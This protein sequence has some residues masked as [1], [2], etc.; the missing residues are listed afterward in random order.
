MWGN[1]GET[2]EGRETNH[3]D[4][5]GNGLV[6]DSRGWDWVDHDNT[7][8]D[9]NGH[10]THVAGTIGAR[11][12]NAVGV[13]GVDWHVRIVP[14]RA[15][16][17]GGSGFVSDL[18][19]AYNYAKQ[20][21]IKIVNASLGGDNSSQAE[22]DA[23]A[24]APNTLF[25]VAA[26]NDAANNDI[27]GSFPCNYPL[28][29]VLCVAATDQND[30]LAS[31]SNYG[32]ATVD[33]A[34]PGV[35]IE[36]TYPGGEYAYMDGTSM[37]TPHVSGTA[38]LVWSKDPG[39]TAAVV[40]QTLFTSADPKP[41][42]L[43]KTVTGGRLNASRA[44]GVEPPTVTAPPLPPVG[45]DNSPPP[46]SEPPPPSPSSDRSSPPARGK[47]SDRTPPRVSLA[48]AR[49]LSLGS[50]LRRGLRASVRCSERC[51]FRVDLLLRSGRRQVSIGSARGSCSAGG[52]KTVRLKVSKRARR[53]LRAARA[54]RLSLR[55]RALDAA[56]NAGSA[57]AAPRLRR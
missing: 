29:N 50:V 56:G 52:S 31:F 24:A 47:T 36:S 15:L 11:G 20:K 17:A 43:G 7:P 25:V 27:S 35:S 48:V 41:S 38:A 4:D 8:F 39:D 14:L 12:D 44:L 1:P 3:V 5:D 53:S 18:I 2:G 40:R 55:V 19:S 37:A 22:R 45:T 6:D 21:G 26:G 13:A 42:L 32:A 49:R 10:G 16:D 51:S 23:I 28:A 34:A 30:D 57:R 9:Q 54:T 33:L 46:P